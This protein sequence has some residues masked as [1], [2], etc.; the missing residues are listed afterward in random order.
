V[1]DAANRLVVALVRGYH[2]VRGGLRVEVLTDDPGARFAPGSRLYPEGAPEP[3]TVAE[4]WPAAPGWII[5]FNEIASRNAAAAY[6]SVY[7]EADAALVPALPRGS[8]YWHELVGCP[9]VDPTGAALGTVRDVYRSGGAEIL[10]VEGGPRGPFDLP[11]ARPFVRIL[12]PRRGEIVADPDALDLPTPDQI[13]P[14]RPPRPPRTRKGEQ[15]AGRAPA[16]FDE[17]DASSS[18][19]PTGAPESDAAVRPDA[20]QA[21][22]ESDAAVRPDG[23][24]EIAPA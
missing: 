12:A 6:L 7:L 24:S 11:V 16:K 19:A 22:P 9:V 15:Q 20:A 3:L 10:V 13:R 21:T 23:A 14:P 17:P 8:Y 4:A 2:G 5:R 1:G 18:A